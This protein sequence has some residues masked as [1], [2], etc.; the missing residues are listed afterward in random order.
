MQDSFFA[1]VGREHI[2]IFY[3]SV[4]YIIAKGNYATVVDIDK[5][6]KCIHHTLTCLEEFLPS[7]LFTR[8]HRS[9]IISLAK[10]EK[11]DKDTVFIDGEQIPVNEQSQEILYKRL[12][13]VPKDC[14]KSR[15]Q[16][17]LKREFSS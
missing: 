17:N 12:N 3:S 6:K 4:L 8:V 11:F 13:V 10:V 14:E 16:K 7:H 9:Y 15:V 2:R 1:S 5:Q